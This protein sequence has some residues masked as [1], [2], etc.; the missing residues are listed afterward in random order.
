[1]KRLLGISLA[2]A[3]FGFGLSAEAKATAP[4]ASSAAGMTVSSSQEWRRDR[5]DR[6]V[7]RR[8]AVR[9]VTQARV[10]RIGRRL[11]RETYLV[12]YLPNGRTNTRLISR[13]RIS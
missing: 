2:L 1:M 7:Y 9:R 8:R 13:V 5:W 10:I 11:Y 3:S 6:R 4:S 12:S